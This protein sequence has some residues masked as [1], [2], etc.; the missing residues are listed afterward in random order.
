MTDG[1][2]SVR[3]EARVDKEREGWRDILS[4][5]YI[6]N[7]DSFIKGISINKYALDREDIEE[8]VKLNLSK[9][10]GTRN[11]WPWK[12][13]LAPRGG[14]HPRALALLK[15]I[16]E[17]EGYSA[18]QGMKP[19]EINFINKARD[20]SIISTLHLACFDI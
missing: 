6:N 10:Y 2:N 14:C 8:D 17:E 18:D 16:L 13:I 1:N 20:G 9:C 4:R 7:P 12:I 19:E 15:A 3:K 5:A 11:N